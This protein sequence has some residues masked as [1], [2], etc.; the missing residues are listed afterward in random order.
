MKGSAWWLAN[1]SLL[2]SRIVKLWENAWEEFTRFLRFDTEIRR[3]VCTTGPIESVNARIRRTV[4]ARGHFLNEQTARK[5]VYMAIVSL[6]PTGKGQVRWTMRWKT[7]L[8]A[9]DITCD[10]RFSAAHQ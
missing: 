9:F 4:K 10:G 3:I 5:C 7:A 8:N 1:D 2:V 6:D